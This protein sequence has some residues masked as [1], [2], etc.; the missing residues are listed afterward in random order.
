MLEILNRFQ[1]RHSPELYTWY[2]SQITCRRVSQESVTN[3][4]NTGASASV[5]RECHSMFCVT[6]EERKWKVGYYQYL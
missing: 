4:A 6:K 2:V 5:A 3:L 1:F